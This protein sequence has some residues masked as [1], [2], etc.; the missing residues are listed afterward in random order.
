MKGTMPSLFVLRIYSLL[1]HSVP[2]E[3]ITSM[4]FITLALF[5]V[6]QLSQAIKHSRIVKGRKERG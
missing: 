3:S 6:F 1:I 4:E 5:P 2:R